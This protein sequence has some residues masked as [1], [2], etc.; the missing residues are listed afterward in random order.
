MFRDSCFQRS[1]LGGMG[2]F[3]LRRFLHF[4]TNILSEAENRRL[5]MP[6]AFYGAG[7]IV[8]T[9]AAHYRCAHAMLLARATAAPTGHSD[10]TQ[11]RKPH[12]VYLAP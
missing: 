8:R 11:K 5:A 3:V 1:L 2:Y 12:S 9:L 7:V 4:R 6:A 10:E